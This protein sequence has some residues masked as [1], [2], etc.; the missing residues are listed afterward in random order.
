[1][2]HLLACTMILLILDLSKLTSNLITPHKMDLKLKDKI[3]LVTGSTAGIGNA[4]ARSLATEGAT[5]YINGRNQTKVN[6][7]VEKLKA[8]TGNA[9]IKGIAAD[10][11][12][13][14]QVDALLKHITRG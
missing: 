4:I 13:S 6:E 7:A 11:A 14:Q 2:K 10:F 8:E 1:M 5:V 9:N 3:A 12:N